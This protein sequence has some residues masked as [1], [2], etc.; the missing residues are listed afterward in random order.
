MKEGHIDHNDIKTILL[1]F[2]MPGWNEILCKI[3]GDDYL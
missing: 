2:E 1:M 3:Y